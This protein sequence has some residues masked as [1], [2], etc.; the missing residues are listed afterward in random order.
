MRHHYDEC[1]LCHET[2]ENQELE[3]FTYDIG[4]RE[5]YI[6]SPA[7]SDEDSDVF[8]ICIKCIHRIKEFDEE[9]VR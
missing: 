1:D 4:K 3:I 6:I 2:N 7:G 9:G 8:Y 5:K